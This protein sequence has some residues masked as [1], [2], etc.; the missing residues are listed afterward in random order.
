MY[1]NNLL[2]TFENGEI[3]SGILCKQCNFCKKYLNDNTKQCKKIY[4]SLD[5]KNNG[6]KKCPYG[7]YIY[8]LNGQ[9]FNGIILK[10]DLNSK[11][12]NNLGTEFKLYPKY[13]VDE[14]ENMVK[15]NVEQYLQITKY[16]TAKHDLIN[17]TTTF[18]AIVDK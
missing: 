18:N 10:D 14:I 8:N 5:L 12:K 16:R 3:K 15:Y 6:L 1:P 2:C 9:I 17:M 7:L 11:V 13:Y 4:E